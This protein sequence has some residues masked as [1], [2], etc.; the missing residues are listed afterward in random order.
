MIFAILLS[1]PRRILTFSRRGGRKLDNEENPLNTKIVFFVLSF[2][3][4]AIARLT[5]AQQSGKIFRIGFLDNALLPV[6][7]SSWRR[8]GKS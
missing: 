4:M 6:A 1:T 3:L 7:R 8:S 5:P 2:S